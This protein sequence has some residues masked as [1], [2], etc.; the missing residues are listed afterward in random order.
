MFTRTRY[1]YGSL[2]LKK[3]RNGPDAWEFRYYVDDSDG[4][5]KRQYLTVGTKE[6]YPTQALARKAVQA[7]LLKLNAETPR[8]ELQVPSFGT[9]LD[10]FKDEEMPTRYSTRKSYESM[11]KMHIRPK[12]GDY[13]LDR[14][15]PMAIEQWLRQL[16]LAPKTKAH[17]RSLMHLVFTCAERWCL[18]EMGKNPIALVRVK[19][20]TKRLKRPRILTIEQFYDLL[21]R[22]KEPY[23]TMVIV[24]QSLGLRVSEIVALQWGDF[25]FD[26]LTLL[27]QRS[28]VCCRVDFVKTEYSHDFVPLDPDLAEVLKSW[29]KK[30]EFKQDIDWVFPNPATGNPFYQEEIQKK[31]IKPAG[32]AAKLGDDIGWHTFRHTYRTLLDETGAPMKV[33]QELM[34]HASI[35]T[36]MN[37][38]GQALSSSKRQANSK[39]V[40]MVL[41]RVLAGA[42]ENGA[43]AAT[44]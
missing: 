13:P 39:V 36:T 40:Q 44:P 29:R 26:N 33:Q 9:L 2:R 34:R 28:A 32:K 8:S 3:R 37:V 4:K 5:R 21:P 14:M 10:K 11:I 22:L 41:K 27:V 35:Q 23:R 25:D 15:K 38:Y 42:N 7:L 24:A 1:Q 43:A 18:I 30:S 20:C 6:Q 31:H 17:I 16:A 12:W 19:D